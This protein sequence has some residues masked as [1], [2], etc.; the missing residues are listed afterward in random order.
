MELLSQFIQYDRMRKKNLRKISDK[1]KKN[2]I[3]AIVGLM[4]IIIGIA[5]LI[6]VYFMI[7][8]IETKVPQSVE[9]TCNLRV[10]R[11]IGRNVFIVSPKNKVN[12]SKT[13]LYFHGGAYV[14]E[15]TEEHWEFIE[16]IVNDTRCNCY[17]TRLSINT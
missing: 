5:T 4:L 13:I 7:A 8:D 16:K 11:F 9:A 15:A 1:M 14:A 17:T 2:I 12:N 3:R 10:E 6:L